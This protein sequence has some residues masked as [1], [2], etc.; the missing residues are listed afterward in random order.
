M[1][2][3][4]GIMCT[5]LA[6]NAVPM[7]QR[8]DD[9]A[10]AGIIMGDINSDGR[11]DSFDLVLLR[12]LSNSPETAYTSAGDVNGN[13]KIDKEDLQILSDYILG[14]D[15]EFAEPYVPPI[16]QPETS[17]YYASD[18]VYQNAFTE[19]TNTGF[20][21]ESYVNFDNEIGSFVE[22]TI[23]APADGNYNIDFRYANG[24]DI[25]RAV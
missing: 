11:I 20:E 10:G 21:G 6:V 23:E 2:I 13:G 17:R 16:V 14:K 25:Y 5:A 8:I 15:V 4:T 1:R 22:W 7:V 12:Q 9:V 24:T 3:V 18:A 19:T